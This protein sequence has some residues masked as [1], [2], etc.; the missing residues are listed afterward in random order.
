MNGAEPNV[1]PSIENCADPP[2]TVPPSPSPPRPQSSPGRP[3]TEPERAT[4]AYHCT[5]TTGASTTYP[6]AGGEEAI[7][8]SAAGIRRPRL[9]RKEADMRRQFERRRTLPAYGELIRGR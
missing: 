5:P 4:T 8:T 9:H 1:A 2:G 7:S 6:M 3:S